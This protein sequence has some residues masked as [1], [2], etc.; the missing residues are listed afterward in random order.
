MMTRN[1][2]FFLG[3]SA[4]CW[5]WHAVE[6]A[7][8]AT[9]SFNKAHGFY[10][11]AFS[12]TVTTATSGA[13]LFYTT[14]GS[15]PTTSSTRYTGAV[16]IPG[17]RCL[18]AAAFMSGLTRSKVTTA[19]Y[20]FLGD[21]IKQAKLPAGCP[22]QWRNMFD[23]GTPQTI[24][25]DYEMDPDVVNDARYKNTIVNDLKAIPTLSIVGKTADMLGSYGVQCR[26]TH[27]GEFACSVELIHADNP[28]KGFQIDCAIRPH[29]W[30]ME[31]RAYRLLFKSP[32]GPTQLTYPIF[33]D[34]PLNAG[35]AASRFDRLVLRCGSNDRWGGDNGTYAQD[36]W[37]RQSQIAM[38]GYGAHGTFM[39]TYI[40]G[41]YWGVYNPVE[42]PDESFLAAYFGGNKADYFAQHH[43]GDLSGNDDRW[44]YLINTLGTVDL[45]GSARYEELKQYLDV[46]QFCDY[47]L[48]H[49]Y[50]GCG[51]WVSPGCANHFAGNRNSPAGPARY[52]V[53]DH[54]S[55][56]FVNPRVAG[57]SYTGAW[58][59]PQFLTSAEGSSWPYNASSG[60]RISRLFRNAL[61]NADF[62]TLFADRLYTHGFN[63]GALTDAASKARWDAICAYIERAMVGE[64]ARWGDTWQQPAPVATLDDTWKPARNTV[65][66]YMT[67]NATRLR[68][69]CRAQTMNGYKLYPSLDPPTYSQNGGTVAAGFQLR[70][71]EPATTGDIYYRTDGEDPRVSGGGVRTGTASSAASFTLTL[72]ATGTVK[73]RCKN[74]A[75][76]SA[77]A[78]AT[79]TV[80]GGTSIPAAPGNLAAAAQSSNSIKLTWTDNSGNE[81]QF[82]ID[83]R[84]SGGST[85]DRIAAPGANVTTYT[86]S[87]LAAGTTY[88]YRVK[89]SNANGDSA[90]SNVAGAT[91][92]SAAQPQIAVSTASVSVSC[93]QGE[94]PANT[95]FQ[96]WNGADGTLRYTIT[97]DTSKLSVAPA[98]GTSAGTADKRTHTISWTTA[99]LAPGVYERT[100]TVADDGSGAA[101]SPVTVAVRITVSEAAAPPAAP[102]G[103]TAAALS[104]SEV[105]LS[106]TDN[107]DN[108]EDF[109]I[110]WN[111]AGAPENSTAIIVPAD[112]SAYTHTGLSPNTAYVYI[113]KAV[114]TTL[115]DSAYTDPVEVTT[116][117]D[118]PA[119]TAFTAYND[120]AWESGQ[121]A[122]NI[123]AYSRGQGGALVDYRTGAALGARLSLDSGGSGP[124]LDQGANAAGGTDAGAVFNGIVDCR[125]LIAYDAA[126]LV[127][128]FSGLDPA[129]SYEV[130]VFG[131]RD[132]ALYTDRITKNWIGGADSFVNAASAGADFSGPADASTGIANGYN[133]A[134][135]Y[136]ARFTEVDPGADGLFELH[137]YDNE[138][139][140]APKFYVNAVMLSAYGA[141]GNTVVEL[142]VDSSTRDV[143]ERVGSGTLYVN[144][145]DLE[146]VM[147]GSREQMVGLRFGPVPIPYGATVRAAYVQFTADEAHTES[148]RLTIQGEAADD[149]RRFG[150]STVS[151]RARTLA[152]ASWSPPGWAIGEA[153]AAQRTPDLSALVQ[154]IVDRPGWASGNHLA[155][156]VTGSG[157]R[158]AVAFDKDPAQAALLHVEYGAAA[159]AAT[160]A[161]PVATGAAAPPPPP[162]DADANGLDDLWEY[163][164]FVNGV[165]A[166]DADTD[167]DGLSNLEEFIAGSDPDGTDAEY[168]G[169]KLA[170]VDGRLTLT[171]PAVIPQA[172]SYAGQARFY[173]LE[174]CA[175]AAGAGGWSIVP[176]YERVEAAEQAVTYAPPADEH[177]GFFRVRVWLEE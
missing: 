122:L 25:A 41:L 19:T 74:G 21:I 138:S 13:T 166:P 158:V 108:E 81:T 29:S 44:D 58:V 164:Y 69:K 36:E 34:A 133:T 94:N 128:R 141:G 23:W 104:P 32:F 68:D 86:D 114:H 60:A 147:D 175:H 112:T 75:T 7:T 67:G 3:F 16:S 84:V 88:Y 116:P 115:G 63:G 173:A 83:R 77:L 35:G 171:L 50:S 155:L 40:N 78:E 65:R 165:G 42:R 98:S 47:I 6:A 139:A 51:D 103:L 70:I 54:E 126:N 53:W 26:S 118:T 106:W 39:H 163:Q 85:W 130:V 28:S 12:V 142:R 66:N 87:G 131:N 177:A 11:S 137:V 24:A 143:E 135:G 156:I 145:S 149:S 82:K 79:F 22:A 55:S 151:S 2:R 110:R 46:E 91:T 17:T 52:F 71:S 80:T 9:P 97:D 148:T 117:D 134:N 113:I 20:I 127:M 92:E 146:M 100:I 144:S 73:A 27:D 119:P 89:A 176:G 167:G 31:K 132:N 174:T 5:A 90:Y 124:Y 129:L 57:R 109:K 162:G 152:S 33:E 170:V 38:T 160:G 107:S 150:G 61:R 1:H 15:V 62:R 172:A 59:K 45:S 96:V 76:W 95:T 14:D 30:V 123:T 102:S 48:L 154:E 101:N 136:V 121:L 140:T 4:C 93:E 18:R 72:N 8:V 111:P 37:A 161:G 56:W 153:G 159:A 64:S 99:D 49:W 169:V 105:R 168:L 125:G 120:L 10:T 157:R 43:A